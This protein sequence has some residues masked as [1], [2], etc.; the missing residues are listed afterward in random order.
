MRTLYNCGE[1]DVVCRISVYRFIVY[2]MSARVELSCIPKLDATAK[3]DATYLCCSAARR[4]ARQ[5]NGRRSPVRP[6][7]MCTRCA[8][9]AIYFSR[10]SHAILIYLNRGSRLC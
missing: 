5:S 1:G 2:R 8:V 7:S 6:L 3:L 4:S 9:S 10:V